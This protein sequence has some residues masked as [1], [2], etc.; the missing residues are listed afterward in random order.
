M[1]KSRFF[2]LKHYCLSGLL[3]G[4]IAFLFSLGG[5]NGYPAGTLKAQTH[6]AGWYYVSEV[7]DDFE[8]SS[9]F[10]K[11]SIEEEGLSISYVG[12]VAKMM[13]R[14]SEAVDGGELIYK[15][16]MIYQFCSAAL[17]FKLFALD[18]H[19]IAACPLGVFIYEL[20]SKPGFVYIG[21]RLPPGL[22]GGSK[23]KT[24]QTAFQE[25]NALL[26][27]IVKRAIE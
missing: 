17:G 23:D 9:A 5:Y 18:P 8:T 3:M 24:V 26:E 27:R 6:Q 11:S 19:N 1:M 10:L 2:T 13:A 4:A 16:A 22:S 15:E 21:Y 20:K 12:H 25:T 14:T 7:E